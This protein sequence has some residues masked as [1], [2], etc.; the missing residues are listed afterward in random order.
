MH[1]LITGTR[2]IPAN[3]GGFETF[4]QDL[5]LFM[6]SRGHEVTVY[7]QASKGEKLR[8]DH[9]KSIRR[10][11]IPV[12]N[13]PVGT[14]EFDLRSILHSIK[15]GGVVLTLGCNTGM[16]NVLYRLRGVPNLL[17]MDGVEWERDKWPGYA[18]AWLRIN[19]WFGARAATHLIADHPEM[20]KILL[21]DVSAKK[22]EVIPYGADAVLSA[23]VAPIEKLG[24]RAKQYHLVIA[25]SEPENSILEIVGTYARRHRGIPL[26][27]L[28]RY[29]REGTPYQNLVLDAA[30]PETLFTGPIYDRSIVNS[31][32]FHARTYF[33]GHRVGGTNPSLVEAL[34]AGNAVVAHSNP[35]NRWVA[36][37]GALYFKQP[38]DLDE[39]IER[40]NS[41]NAK[42]VAMEAASRKRHSEAFT[43]EMILTAYEKILLRFSNGNA[44]LAPEAGLGYRG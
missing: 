5:S 16:F 41:D 38:E 12:G 37:D 2:G 14:M 26:V 21:D 24:L 42:L 35:F 1:V 18:K 36:G 17:N 9:W 8:E 11:L 3:Y 25:R 15:Q 20:G 33:H 43:Q 28:G 22:I 29:T 40:V 34:A 19:K 31:L 10:V 13:G 32:R 7:C 23:P 6:R 30:G 44:V 27:I 39:I 4:A